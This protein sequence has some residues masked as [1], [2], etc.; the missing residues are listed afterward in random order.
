V[1]FSSVNVSEPDVLARFD[2]LRAV[3]LEDVDFKG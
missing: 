1:Q 2:S 3:A